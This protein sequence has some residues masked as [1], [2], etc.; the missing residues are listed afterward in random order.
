M[1]AQPLCWN[2]HL[3]RWAAERAGSGSQACLP[4]VLLSA[5]I[6]CTFH[7][8]QTPSQATA[9]CR[10]ATVGC[11]PS[12][13]REHQERNAECAD[14]SNTF[15]RICHG[16]VSPEGA[17][18]LPDAAVHHHKFLT[19]HRAC[20]NCHRNVPNAGCRQR[21]RIILAPPYHLLP[22]SGRCALP[23]GCRELRSTGA[24]GRAL[25]GLHWFRHSSCL[26]G[27]LTTGGRT[28]A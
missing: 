4:S 26:Q 7:S 21:L 15:N 24:C 5:A 8:A 20:I 25:M 9:V 22:P 2:C 28:D 10:N 3:S 23:P 6:I 14:E 19:P 12:A 1:P 11:R 27:Q 16:A 18:V 17:L 13:L